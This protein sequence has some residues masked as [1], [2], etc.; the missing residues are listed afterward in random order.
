MD[1]DKYRRNRD[2]GLRGQ[3]TDAEYEA[4]ME[5]RRRQEADKLKR[6]AKP[7]QRIS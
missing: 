6:N 2:A 4:V 7:Q 3:A 1:K 5:L